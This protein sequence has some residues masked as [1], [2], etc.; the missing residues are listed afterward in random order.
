MELASKRKT[1]TRNLVR[2]GIL[3]ALI[4][5]MTVVPYTGYINYGLVEITTLHIVVAV[6]ASPRELDSAKPDGERILTWK[7]LYE[8]P[9][10]PEHLVV[11][12]SG[13]TG[14]EFANAYRTL[15]SE[16]T[17]RSF[18]S[19]LARMPDAGDDTDFAPRRDMPRKISS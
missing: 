8:L 11:V 14:A 15:G 10:I 16:V 19:F 6:G 12:G 7:Q 4:I 17:R 3:S 9:S 1:D 13:V 2:A 5:V 18:K